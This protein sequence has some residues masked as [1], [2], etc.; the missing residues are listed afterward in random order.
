MFALTLPCVKY[1]QISALF[2]AAKIILLFFR[3]IYV[4]K[5]LQSIEAK[6]EK[7]NSSLLSIKY[8][9][10]THVSFSPT[11]LF[12]IILQDDVLREKIKD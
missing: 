5:Y 11:K 2:Y 7:E 12:S 9:Q 3:Q 8:F 4:Y 6:V 1:I 10:N